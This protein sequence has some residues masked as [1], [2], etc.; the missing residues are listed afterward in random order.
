MSAEHGYG[1]GKGSHILDGWLQFR[2]V[3]AGLLVGEY[4]VV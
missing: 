2:Y 3:L 4:L 1:G